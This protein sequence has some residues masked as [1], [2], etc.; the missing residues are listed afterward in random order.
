MRARNLLRPWRGWRSGATGWKSRPK[1]HHAA[2]VFGP[3]LQAPRASVTRRDQTFFKQSTSTN[4]RKRAPPALGLGR[5]LQPNSILTA[6][7]KTGWRRTAAQASPPAPRIPAVIVTRR[8]GGKRRRTGARAQFPRY[9]GSGGKRGAIAATAKQSPRYR[10]SGGKRGAIAAKVKQS[11]RYRGL[12][13]ERGDSQTVPPLSGVRGQ[14]RGH[15]SASQTVPPL[16]GVR[17]RARGPPAVRTKKPSQTVSFSPARAQ[18]PC[19]QP[20]D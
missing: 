15:R 10:G 4:S 16:S 14:A 6:L 12:G 2:V 11:P 20:P 5:P 17:G 8:Q 9:R 1:N 3:P 19:S 18:N 7:P 13:G